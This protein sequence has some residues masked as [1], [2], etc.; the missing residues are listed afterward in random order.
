ME[1]P[2]LRCRS[3]AAFKPLAVSAAPCGARGPGAE[4]QCLLW[5]PRQPPNRVTTWSP[6]QPLSDGTCVGRPAVRLDKHMS[7]NAIPKGLCAVN[8]LLSSPSATWRTWGSWG[9]GS[10]LPAHPPSS[11]LW[12]LMSSSFPGKSL[13]LWELLRA[14]SVGDVFPQVQATCECSLKARCR[15]WAPSPRKG[16]SSKG[17][18]SETSPHRQERAQPPLLLPT[19]ARGSCAVGRALPAPELGEHGGR[20]GT[21]G[22]P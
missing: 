20:G 14:E 4:R 10:S 9:G 6:G 19:G 18:H 17:Q 13:A 5:L 3:G 22:S 21:A 12:V 15:A 16:P 11:Q 2:C 8:Q 1:C 7:P